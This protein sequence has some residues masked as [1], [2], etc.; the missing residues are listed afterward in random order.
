MKASQKMCSNNILYKMYEFHLLLPPTNY[1]FSK[2][3]QVKTFWITTTKQQ[4]AKKL[5][6]AAGN[7]VTIE[8]L[9]SSSS[10]SFSFSFSFSSSSFSQ[11]FTFWHI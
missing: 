4:S 10:F 1:N 9:F 3:N 5:A 6:A 11:F 2:S 8:K 7:W